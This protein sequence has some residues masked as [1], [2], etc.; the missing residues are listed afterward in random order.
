VGHVVC[1]VE[2]RYAHGYFF[3]KGNLKGHLEHLDLYR[4]LQ[5]KLILKKYTV[6]IWTGSY[7]LEQKPVAISYE[8]CNDNSGSVLT[9]W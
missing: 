7:G 8:Q 9:E 5:L 1:I 3:G 4:R 2:L 6:K